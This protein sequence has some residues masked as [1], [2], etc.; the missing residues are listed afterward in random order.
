VEAPPANTL[1][2][3]HSEGRERIH[4][5]ERPVTIRYAFAG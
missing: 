1:S 2:D 4:W 3:K 5:A